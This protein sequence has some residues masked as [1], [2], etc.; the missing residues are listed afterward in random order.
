[1]SSSKPNA[2]FFIMHDIGRRYGCYG[3]AQVVSP[4]IDKLAS[5]AL[6]F[7]NHFCHW[8]LCGPS[9]ANIFSG[10]RPLS[11]ERYNNQPFFP[12]FRCPPG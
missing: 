3:N 8:P 5:D 7:E 1:M 12:D 4:N 2:L 10:L 9:R 11:T 6:R